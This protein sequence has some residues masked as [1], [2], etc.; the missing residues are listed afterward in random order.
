VKL[1][2]LRDLVLRRSARFT[3]HISEFSLERGEKVAIVGPNG[4]GKT[5]LLRLLSLLEK[6][7]SC[8]VFSYVGRPDSDDVDRNG[9]GFLQ[10]QPYLFRGTVAQNLAYPLK[11]RQLSTADVKRCVEATLAT[12]ELEHLAHERARELSGGEQKRLAL[13]R[14]L[15][16]DPD[17]LLLDEPTSHL[18]A[19]SQSVIEA[20]LK[21]TSKTILLA[22]H[23]LPF[24]LRVTDRVL[25]LREGRVTSSLPENIFE[26]FRNGDI[27]AIANGMRIGLPPDA[28]L[29]IQKGETPVT[30]AIDPKNIALSLES[31]STAP[32]NQYRGRI[33]ALR[34]QGDDVWLKVDC[35]VHLTAIIS[36]AS[37][38]ELGVNLHQEVFV[39][40]GP[41]DVEIL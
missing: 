24:A 1:Y 35:G 29:P 3:L 36:R 41:E 34:G 17:V 22:T 15:I 27:V 31:P 39:S 18:D 28:A 32:Q 8:A 7:D 10:Q 38:E 37:Y 23:N 9:M 33:S 11:V 21:E 6:P 20:F 14:V 40:F 19:R 2:E 4:S 5:T 25:H 30:I 12:M 26:G 13:G 16:A